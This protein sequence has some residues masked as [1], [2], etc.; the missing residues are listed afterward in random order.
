MDAREPHRGSYQIRTLTKRIRT[1]VP[2]YVVERSFPGLTNKHLAAMQHAL[3]EACHRQTASGR[4][5]HY[6]GTTFLPARSRCLCLFEASNSALVKAVNE[7][8]QVPFASIN[9]AIELPTPK[10]AFDHPTTKR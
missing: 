7:T 9:E 5:I 10:G 4:P 2:V 8:A 1:N 6:R 3:T